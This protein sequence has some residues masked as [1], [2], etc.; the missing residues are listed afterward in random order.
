MRGPSADT[1]TPGP[2]GQPSVGVSWKQPHQSLTSLQ[3]ASNRMT[4]EMLI[5]LPPA[6]FADAP[7]GMTSTGFETIELELVAALGFERFALRRVE[8]GPVKIALIE[9][10]EYRLA[11]DLP[12]GVK[13]RA[14]QAQ[15]LKRRVRIV[16][17]LSSGLTDNVPRAYRL[18]GSKVEGL[19]PAETWPA[20]AALQAAHP[21]I[22]DEHIDQWAG[23]GVT[24][25][26]LKAGARALLDLDGFLHL[27]PEPQLRALEAAQKVKL[28]TKAEA[29]SAVALPLY[30][31]RVAAALDSAESWRD[32]AAI[33]DAL[34]S[35]DE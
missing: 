23:D 16:A 15:A 22:S 29:S 32:L 6:L 18:A 2:S 17:G 33:I 20:L 5:D 13:V 1:P 28:L 12:P 35:E 10:S 4:K 27:G 3:Q 24:L 34:T 7:E 25:A 8:T 19:T 31:Q 30:Q 21:E 9:E 11:V 14:A 26:V